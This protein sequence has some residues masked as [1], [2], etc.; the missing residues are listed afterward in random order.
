[1][2]HRS[3]KFRRLVVET[4]ENRELLSASTC[5]DPSPEEVELLDRINRM[6]IDPQGELARIFSDIEKG[7]AYDSHITDY[8]LPSPAYYYPKNTSILQREFAKLTPAAPLAWDDS[9]ALAADMH[10]TQMINHSPKPMEGHQLPNGPTLEERLI[11]AGFYDPSSGL[12][13]EFEENVT[14]YGFSPVAG[15]YGSVAS[16]I[17]EFFVIDFGQSSHGHRNNVMDPKF[18]LIGIG[19]Q[20]VPQGMTGFG[21]WVVTVD[22]ASFS[23]G[24]ALAEGGYLTGVAYDDANGNHMYNAGEGLGDM[25]IVI[26]KDDGS[27]K[28][29]FSTSSAGAYQEYLNNGTYTVTI[30]GSAFAVPIT[31]TVVIDGQNVKVDFCP[32]DIASGKPLVDLNGA[33]AGLNFDIAFP[34]TTQPSSIVTSGLSV[35]SSGWLTYATLQLQE[36]P[37]GGREILQVNL[38]GTSLAS[39]YDSA[40]GTLTISG[41]AT[42]EDYAKVLRTLSYQNSTERPHLETRTIRV[43]VSNG[44]NESDAAISTVNMTAVYI[45]EMMIEDVKV[46]EGDEGLTDLNFVIELS[47]MPRELIVINYTISAGTAETG[48][49][50]TGTSGRIT[51]NPWDRMTA[52]I[53][54][55]ISANYNSGNDRTILL[56]IISATN[57]TLLRNQVS[58]TILEDDNIERLGNW[59]SWSSGDVNLEFVDGRRFLYSFNAMYDGS[60]SWDTLFDSLPENARVFVYDTT[61]ASD[62]IIALPSLSG[63]KRHLEFDVT[64][65]KTYI[66]KIELQDD[67]EPELWP[68]IVSMKMVQTVRI[69]DDGIEVLGSMN[70]STNYVLDFSNGDLRVGYDDA[71]TQ[72]DPSLYHLIQFG[73]IKS[74]DG[75]TIIGGG[76]QENSVSLDDEFLVTNG[77]SIHIGD[78]GNI[79]FVGT[80]EYDNVQFIVNEDDCYFR[81]ENGKTF[82]KTA[83]KEYH[84]DQV[85]SVT[86]T[87]TGTGGYADFYDLL[88]NDTYTLR[89]NNML[90]EGG[91]FRIET[92]NF[93]KGNA[94]LFSGG[95]DTSL[96]FGE[97]DSQI[98]F[99]DKMIDRLDATT[100]YRIWNPQTAIA[101]NADDSNNVVTFVNLNPN[102]QYYVSL[103][104]V[105]STNQRRSIYHQAIGFNDV[106]IISLANGSSMA[107]IYMTS[108]SRIE[109]MNNGMVLT[110]GLKKVAMPTGATFKFQPYDDR[111]SLLV[112]TGISMATVAALSALSSTNVSVQP[113]TSDVAMAAIAEETAGKTLDDSLLQSL[114]DEQEQKRKTSQDEGDDETDLLRVFA[115]QIALLSQL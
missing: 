3:G 89:T 55:P 26:R 115:R 79:R 30:T 44:F 54:I 106:A 10:T 13:I 48:V 107:T 66:V 47:E 46:I 81:F 110:D 51:F 25:W 35:T 65:G 6:R 17:H 9:L 16:Y 99:T 93:Q 49:D 5:F 11:A 113:A 64:E 101:M 108:D 69:I 22:F 43:I 34:E 32:Q 96:V 57:V 103:A 19:L 75:L 74:G 24:S 18:T 98:I 52:T 41:T 67:L 1:M 23:N 58:G 37:D 70:Q 73:L 102:D 28:A 92:Q 45:P 36:R 68:T 80:D 8:F 97:N 86:V 14:G 12:S 114:A 33:E 95:N 111:Q 27:I 76:S 20:E 60:V 90:F 85:E 39:C 42:A 109:W 100:S 15:K 38:S 87:T 40:T 91:G 31:Q 4:L 63:N 56:D 21:P 104:Y 94:Y 82:L 112:Q 72:I 77:V 83:T 2:S 105:T 29:E 7:I 88:S 62:A 50:F 71:L 53:S 84:T 78:F 59:A 61:H